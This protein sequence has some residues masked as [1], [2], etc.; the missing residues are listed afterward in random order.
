MS[1]LSTRLKTWAH[2]HAPTRERL[3]QNRLLRP[4]ARRPELWRFTR[5]SVP[6][7]V[8]IGLMVA[9]FFVIPGLHIILAAL[10]CV[11]LRANIPLAVGSTL[12]S[13][14]A[15]IPLFV[16]AAFWIGNHLGFHA[17]LA[18][19]H[20]MRHHGAEMVEWK[21]WLLSDAAPALLI[22]LGVIAIVTGAIG[23]VITA[24][25]WR[26]RVARRWHSRVRHPAAS[27]LP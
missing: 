22:G 21:H 17:D 16:A 10:L 15:T 13:N 1:S 14:P 23:Y 26:A 2:S 11:P 12:I 3:E 4:L 20:A 7:G 5:R 25:L 6:R 19:F 9:I 27:P 24:A 8:A 18:T